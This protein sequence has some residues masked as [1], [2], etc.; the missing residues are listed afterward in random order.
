METVD[1]ARDTILKELTSDDTE[2]RDAYLTHFRKDVEEF[3]T[4]MAEAF[5]NWRGLDSGAKTDEKLAYVSALVFTAITL[6]VLSMKLF[7]SGYT[8]A[9]GNLLRQVV[10][11]IALTILCSSKELDILSRFMNGKY[12]TNDAIRDVNRYAKRLGLNK[13]GLEAL[14]S[15]QEFYHEYS[16]PSFLTIAA[17]MSFSEQVSYVGAA[18]DEGKIE[19]YTKEMA[20]RVGLAAVFSNFVDGVKTNV[21]K[22]K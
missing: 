11:T 7:I 3:S 22:W 5:V 13:G 6:H 20:G 9:A 4:A 14:E 16:H 17:G 15:A 12:S 18:F 8:V 2:V 21:A 1:Q 19:V 10:E